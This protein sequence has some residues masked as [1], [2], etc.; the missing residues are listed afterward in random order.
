MTIRS[1]FCAQAKC[2]ESAFGR[3]FFWRGLYRH[4]VPLAAL[5]QLFAPGF[6]RDDRAFIEYV[7]GDVSLGEL[8]EDIARFEYGNV[9][10]QH[11]LRTGLRIR[12]NSA[13]VEALA[14]GCVAG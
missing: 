14:Q 3:R 12:V 7:G 5:I 6:F 1:A 2:P 4:A 11:W 10:R 13:R 8:R 9:V